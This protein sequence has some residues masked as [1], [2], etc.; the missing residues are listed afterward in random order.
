MQRED[1]VTFSDEW[2]LVAAQT[3]GF[4]PGRSDGVRGRSWIPC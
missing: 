3:R 1:R 2:H 4:L